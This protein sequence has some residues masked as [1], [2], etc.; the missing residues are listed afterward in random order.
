MRKDGAALRN[1]LI[2][3]GTTIGMIVVI[4]LIARYIV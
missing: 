3:A 1:G 2:L 4:A